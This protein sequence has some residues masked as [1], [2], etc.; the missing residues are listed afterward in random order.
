[1]SNICG[2]VGSD[3]HW[4]PMKEVDRLINSVDENTDLHK[5][6]EVVGKCL[7]ALSLKDACEYMITQKKP[8]TDENIKLFMN[9]AA[10]CYLIRLELMKKMIL[11]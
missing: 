3:G 11:E 1:M 9:I 2:C 7:N 5:I 8:M 4:D 6:A 10:Q